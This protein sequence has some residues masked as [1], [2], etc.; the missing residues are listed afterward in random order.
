MNLKSNVVGSSIPSLMT[1]RVSQTGPLVSN[2][3]VAVATKSLIVTSTAP[4][5]VKLGAWG[6]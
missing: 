3:V 2:Q 1:E 6:R 4:E 5:R